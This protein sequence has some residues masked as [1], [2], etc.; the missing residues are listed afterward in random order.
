MTDQNQMVSDLPP[1]DPALLSW[2]EYW[3]PVAWKGLLL[4]GL[5]TAIAACAG[6][7]F[8]LLQWRA[9]SILEQQS[10]WRTSSL[11]FQARKAEANLARAKADI[12]NADAR[13]AEARLETERLKKEVAWPELNPDTIGK[14]VAEL[15][16]EP[17]KIAI[18]WLTGDPES[19]QYSAQFAR[20]FKRA[21]WEFEIIGRT[22]LGPPEG[23]Y[24]TH[25]KVW[26]RTIEEAI[27]RVRK[28]LVDA[29]VAVQAGDAPVEADAPQLSVG[30]A[31]ADIRLV[32][33]VKPAPK[34]E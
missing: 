12:A 33:G 22:F 31:T 19:A 6:I 18:V 25:N 32:V 16:K 28:T 27:K 2:A 20:V 29:G 11:E 10:N 34:I 5:L 1:I 4:A 23:L 13:A 26:N 21:K 7:A 15:S 9:S 17:A 30:T 14:L 8:L 3:Y 24:V